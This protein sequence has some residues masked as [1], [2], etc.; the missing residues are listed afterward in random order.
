MNNVHAIIPVAGVGSRLRPHTYSAPKVLVHVA[1]KPILG[2]ILDELKELGI[3]RLTLIVGHLGDMIRDYVDN[4]YSFETTYV[5]QEE[6]R[7]LGHAIYLTREV[8]RPEEKMFI[9]LG[10]TIFKCDLRSVLSSQQ[11]LIGVKE[12][13]DPKRFGIIELQ[14]DRI[15]GMQEKPDEPK[16]NLA[17]VGIYYLTQPNLLFQ[18]L[19]ELIE[20]GQTTKGEFQLTDALQKMIQN[21]TVFKPFLVDGW[22]DCGKPETLLQTNREILTHERPFNSNHHDAAYPNSIINPPVS[23]APTA[24]V[25]SSIIGPYVTVADGAIIKNSVIR[26]SIISRKASVSNIYLE[27]SII[28]DNAKVESK[29]FRL[30]VGDSSELSLG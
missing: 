23:I 20:S 6:L 13:T 2:H 14:G 26:D 28:S 17:I 22:Y 27:R 29:P 12:V 10:D 24:L 18:A 11:N 15:A 30:N 21:G 9:V 1:G 19:K 4:C 25:D 3:K 16:T 8:V 5:H 7:G